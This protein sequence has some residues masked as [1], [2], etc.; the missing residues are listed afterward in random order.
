MAPPGRLPG[1][2]VVAETSTAAWSGGQNRE[3]GEGTHHTNSRA[4]RTPGS[5]CGG[6]TP[7]RGEAGQHARGVV[8]SEDGGEGVEGGRRGMRAHLPRDAQPLVRL[9]AVCEHHLP[10]GMQAR[11]GNR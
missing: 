2:Y 7:R 11:K 6:L 1:D 9:R 4:E 8:S 10:M 3:R 5:S